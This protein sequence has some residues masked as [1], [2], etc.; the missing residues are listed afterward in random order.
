M[1]ISNDKTNHQRFKSPE[2]KKPMYLFI[3]LFIYCLFTAALQHMEV[4]RL[5]VE[6]ELPQ[7]Q[8]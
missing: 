8:I 7:R 5:G 4:P 2:E 3:Y 6:W 1:T